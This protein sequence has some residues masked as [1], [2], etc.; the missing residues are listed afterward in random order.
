M[1]AGGVLAFPAVPASFRIRADPFGHWSDGRLGALRRSCLM[2]LL[3]VEDAKLAFVF[4]S[5]LA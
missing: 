4:S 1:K 3:A 2:V 5:V